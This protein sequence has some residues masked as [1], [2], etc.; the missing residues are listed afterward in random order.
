MARAQKNAEESGFESIAYTVLYMKRLGV[1][2]VAQPVK[3][4]LR[5]RSLAS[6]SGLKIQHYCKLWC[7][8]QMG[9]GSHVVVAVAQAKSC[10]SDSTPSPETAICYR[11]V[12]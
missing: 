1:P 2:I 4:W 12:V 9:L 7:K 8:L 10:S 6:L 11:F 3:N 5:V